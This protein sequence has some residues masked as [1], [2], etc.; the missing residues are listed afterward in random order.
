[1]KKNRHIENLSE[2]LT[3]QNSTILI[4]Q[5][6]V[7]LVN[8][9]CLK[10]QKDINTKCDESEQCSRRQCLRIEGIVKP[11]KEKAEDVINLVEECF[12]EAYVD[13]SDTALDRTHKTGPVYKDDDE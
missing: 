2:E 13:I 3:Q 5:N 7:Q 9:H 10:L 4:L 11:P 12:A 6:N 1:M 8:E